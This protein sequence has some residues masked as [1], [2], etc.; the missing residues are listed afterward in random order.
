MNAARHRRRRLHRLQ[1]RPPRASAHTD[2]TGDRARQAD[3]R[4]Q[5]GVARRPAGGPARASS[6]GDICDAALVDELVAGARPGRALRG[7]VAQ[8][9]LAA[10]TRRRSCG[11]T[12]SA[13]TRCSRRSASTTSRFHHISTDEVYGDLELD[14]PER[15]TEDTAVQPVA[16]RTPRPRPAPTCWS[17]P[18]SAASACGPRSPTAPTTTG[19]TSTSRSSS[20]AR[21]PTCSTAS[22]RELY[23]DGQQRARLDPRRRPLP[24]PCC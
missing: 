20:R 22:G 19:R 5:P 13:P 12:W 18:G 3:L 6:Q 7:R 23:G 8:R 24:P 14:D 9:Q 1:L 21:S 15:F 4:R 11:P 2:V 16:A 10:T 17:A